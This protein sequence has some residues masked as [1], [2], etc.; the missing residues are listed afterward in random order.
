MDWYYYKDDAQHGPVPGDEIRARLVSGELDP[1]D[2]VWCEGMEDW[3]RA[4]ICF[5]E[6]L[7]DEE[8]EQIEKIVEKLRQLETKASSKWSNLLILL[9][10]I[11][12]FVL[13]GFID[14]DLQTIS[15]I[16][17][18]VFFH[19]LGHALGMRFFGYSNVKILF[20][21]FFGALAS[22]KPESHGAVD[23]CVVT[24]LGPLPGLIIGLVVFLPT[25]FDVELPEIIS[26]IAIF[27][28]LINGF[29]LLPL[30]PLD[31]G[32]IIN[33]ALAY[34]KPWLE[35]LFRIFGA[36][37]LIALGYFLDSML[38]KIFGVISFFTVRLQHVQAQIAHEFVRN[39]GRIPPRE[40]QPYEL[41]TPFLRE[42]K[43]YLD[44]SY[45]TAKLDVE[46][47]ASMFQLMWDRIRFVPATKTETGVILAVYLASLAASILAAGIFIVF[48]FF[49]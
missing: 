35:T 36:L 5:S 9:V 4:G 26:M 23:R 14:F 30:L 49:R 13:A 45:K 3:A 29:N 48:A 39:P 47:Y 27:L 24:L 8:Q 18:V 28:I 44:R 43:E 11:A 46:T 31:G 17:G 16:V 22:G 10:S 40:L 42:M 12:L 19:E 34:R 37:G 41:P 21:P 7:I 20:I 1:A 15:I 33:D 32:H 25:L 2:Y 6:E 38:L